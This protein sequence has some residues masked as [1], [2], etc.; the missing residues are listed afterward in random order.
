[1]RAQ[2]WPYHPGLHTQKPRLHTPW[3]EHWLAHVCSTGIC[4]RKVAHTQEVNTWHQVPAV[5]HMETTHSN[6][7]PVAHPTQHPTRP[8]PPCFLPRNPQHHRSCCVLHPAPPRPCCAAHLA[9]LPQHAVQAAGA[10]EGGQV[11]VAPA[12]AVTQQVLPLDRAPVNLG[13]LGVLGRE[14]RDAN[15]SRTGSVWFALGGPAWGTTQ[16]A[17]VQHVMVKGP[18]R[19]VTKRLRARRHYAGWVLG[20][21]FRT[22]I[23]VAV[24]QQRRQRSIQDWQRAAWH[25][26]R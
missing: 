17:G 16:G 4:G 22:F 7:R 24:H 25:C 1:M 23:R 26:L 15:R 9:E 20:L 5:R 21:T 14:Q 18:C 8:H 12:G 3:P 11:C 6:I 2:S 13:A 10:L 19:R